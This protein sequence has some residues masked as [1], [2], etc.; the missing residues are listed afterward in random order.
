MEQ[1]GVQD[2][3]SE[4]GRVYQVV[5]GLYLLAAPFQTSTIMN[6]VKQPRNSK[7]IFPL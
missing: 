6:P 3:E 2:E 7:V 5:A 4:V 1:R